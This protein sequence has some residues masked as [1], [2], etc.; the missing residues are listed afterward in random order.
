[1]V[2]KEVGENILCLQIYRGGKFNSKI[3]DDFCKNQGIQRQL[4]T[5]Y[6]P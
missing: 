5:T 2:E 1:M 6:T 3:F 4:I